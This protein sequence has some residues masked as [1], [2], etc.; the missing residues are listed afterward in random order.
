MYSKIKLFGHPIHPMI[1]AFPV[2]FYVGAFV[3]FITYAFR[4]DIF[5]FRVAITLNI[6]GVFMAMIAAVPG[7]LDLVNVPF[8]AAKRTG[9]RHAV[10]NISAL[11][12]FALNA[13]LQGRNW[14]NGVTNH[15]APILLTGVGVALTLAGGFLGWTMVQKHHV[16]VDLSPEQ[17]A[18][19]PQNYATSEQDRRAIK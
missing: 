6:A 10:I 16:G 11:A 1:V 3:S 2:A 4:F 14:E 12:L 18:L 13:L 9:I 8:G 5:W 19:E 17:E 15:V 7:A